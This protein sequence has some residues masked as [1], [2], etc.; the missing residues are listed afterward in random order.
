[1]ACSCGDSPTSFLSQP[2][3][4]ISS[5]CVLLA[6][7]STE[8]SCSLL[9]PCMVHLGQRSLFLPL[10]PC[11]HVRLDKF[12]ADTPPPPLSL[13]F[14]LQ[15]RFRC[16]KRR[17]EAF[18]DF[19][20]IPLPFPHPCFSPVFRSGRL[21]LRYLGKVCLYLSGSLPS[22]PSLGRGRRRGR[23]RMRLDQKGKQTGGTRG[24]EEMQEWGRRRKGKSGGI[25]SP[26][27]QQK[28]KEGSWVCLGAKRILAITFGQPGDGALAYSQ[29][30]TLQKKWEA[31]KR[32]FSSFPFFPIP[33]PPP[34]C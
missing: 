1:M 24:G 17:P 32:G 20:L 13:T 28:G 29:S 26:F 5:S 9:L 6:V 10:W 4:T 21:R 25:Y 33:P 3:I 2:R 18:W 19:F 16:R 22:P 11:K 34:I 7:R 30:A 31:L 8:E 27:H 14:P 12:R 15:K 23:E